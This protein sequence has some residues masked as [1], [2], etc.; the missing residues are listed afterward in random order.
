MAEKRHN[1]MGTRLLGW[2][3]VL[4]L[5]IV[6]L[7]LLLRAS[8]QEEWENTLGRWAFVVGMPLVGWFLVAVYGMLIVPDSTH[9]TGQPWLSGRVRRGIHYIVIAIPLVL[10]VLSILG[11]HYSAEALAG[12]FYL[13]AWLLL[14]LVVLNAI[15]V[16]WLT[17]SRPKRGPCLFGL[18]NRQRPTLR[19]RRPGCGSSTSGTISCETATAGLCTSSACTAIV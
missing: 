1:A 6:L 16:R 19:S 10:A 12:R 7:I 5:P 9:A 11:Y 8:G 18:R 14:V 2:L 15:A 4:G 17:V 13:T 3:I